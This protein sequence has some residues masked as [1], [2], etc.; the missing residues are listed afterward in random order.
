MS[1]SP[2]EFYWMT[3]LKPGQEAPPSDSFGKSAESARCGYLSPLPGEK[4]MFFIVPIGP[5]VTIVRSVQLDAD[6]FHAV[7]PTSLDSTS[8]AVT[9]RKRADGVY[10]VTVDDEKTPYRFAMRL[11]TTSELE[12]LRLSEPK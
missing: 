2:A 5:C 10:T 11:A 1:E 7:T 8:A 4:G 9:G 3:A 12:R 6:G